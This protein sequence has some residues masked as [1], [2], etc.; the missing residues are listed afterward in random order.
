M[1][2][3][4]STPHIPAARVTSGNFSIPNCEGSE[5]I[6]ANKSLGAAPTLQIAAEAMRSP[7]CIA[8][9]LIHDWAPG[10]SCIRNLSKRCAGRFDIRVVPAILLPVG[11]M[12]TL[13][14][15]DRSQPPHLADDLAVKGFAI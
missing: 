2:T 15:S 5:D 11:V 1:P 13:Q 6:R 14:T 3:K 4:P 9:E 7:E 8:R 12:S 10:R